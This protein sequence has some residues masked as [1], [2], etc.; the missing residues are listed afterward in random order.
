MWWTN[1]SSR[2]KYDKVYTLDMKAL[3]YTLAIAG[4]VGYI[5]LSLFGVI[6]V[7]NMY[8]HSMT[9]MN[10]DCPFMIGESSLCTMNLNEHISLW[11]AFTHTT[12][13][14]LFVIFFSVTLVSFVLLDLILHPPRLLNKYLYQKPLRED[15]I[16][17]L[18]SS[19]ILNSKAF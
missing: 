19:G 6:V 15:F 7:K 13:S 3:K 18:F 14:K 9:S 11:K 2:Q 4:L 5:F 8:H 16:T 10:S 17:S 1:T 12:I